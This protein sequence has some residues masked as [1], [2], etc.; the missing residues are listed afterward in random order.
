MDKIIKIG[1]KGQAEIIGLVIL[2]VI[3]VFILVIALNFSFKQKDDKSDI[4][5]SLI[6]NNLL[7]AI[8]KEDSLNFKNLI[9]EC[10][11]EKKRNN[12]GQNCLKLKNEFNK[13][14]SIVFRNKD[15]Q[16]KIKTDESEFFKEGK[17]ENGIQSTIYRFKMDTAFMITLK[18]C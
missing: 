12:N 2:V 6:A 4:R 3:L 17:C 16:L 18:V 11:I 10:Y 1:N 14:F 5:K 7:N 9:N 15:V 13:L 8:I